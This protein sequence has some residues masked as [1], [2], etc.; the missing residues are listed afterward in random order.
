[1]ND[2]KEVAQK[3][4]GGRTLP[5]DRVRLVGSKP[6]L[7]DLGNQEEHGERARWVSDNKRSYGS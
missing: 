2:E 5:S 3:R 7:L 1:M 6:M 4:P